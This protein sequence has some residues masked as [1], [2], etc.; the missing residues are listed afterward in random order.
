MAKRTLNR[1]L[2]SASPPKTPTRNVVRREVPQTRTVTN[3]NIPRFVLPVALP[4]E[5]IAVTQ[6]FGVPV[7]YSRLNPNRIQAHEGIDFAPR[8]EARNLSNIPVIAVQNA[9]V[10]Q[11]REQQGGYGRYVRLEF[12]GG[13]LG[14]LYAHLDNVNVREGDRVNVGDVIGTMGSSGRSTGRHLHFNLLDLSQSRGNYIYPQVVDPRPFFS[15][16]ENVVR[17]LTGRENGQP[18]TPQTPRN[19]KPL[20]RTLITVTPEGKP[21]PSIRLQPI[22]GSDYPPDMPGTFTPPVPIEQRGYPTSITFSNPVQAA[23]A[24]VAGSTINNPALVAQIANSTNPLTGEFDLLQAIGLGTGDEREE[25]I[26]QYA[27]YLVL[28]LVAII[29]I[30]LGV[31]RLIKG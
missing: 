17:F 7:D 20:P 19:T 5:Q 9:R 1:N 3:T 12:E 22:P 24:A 14:A 21:R 30:G 28:G 29:L 8:G 25:Y 11:V 15:G 27:P 13:E 10:T 6:E 18:V 23:M 4:R 16:A 31:A 26:K 2:K